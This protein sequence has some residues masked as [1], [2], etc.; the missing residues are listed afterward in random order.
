[1]CANRVKEEYEDE[2]SGT[3]EDNEPPCQQD[4]VFKKLQDV[5][6]RADISEGDRHSEQQEWSSRTEQQEPEPPHIKEEEADITE[7]P[8]T[9]VI[10][11]IEDEYKIECDED[12]CEGSQADNLFAPLSDSDN[13]TS[14][15][16]DT[17]DDEQLKGD[18]TCQTDKQ[19]GKCSQCDKSFPS[20]SL[21]KRHMGIHTRE[22][23]LNYSDCGKRQ[24]AE[25]KPFACS[26]CTLTFRRRCNLITHTRT[27]T[28]E[29]PFACLVCAK[30]FARKGPLNVHMRTHTGEK[31]FACS[32][33]GKRFAR[34]AHLNIH[35]RTHTGEKPFACS[36][37][38]F[39]F[40]EHSGLVLHMR[41]HTGEKPYSCSVCGKRF[42]QS[43][44][45]TTHRRT[46]T[47]EKPFSCSVCDEQFSYKYQMNKHKCS[48]EK[49]SSQ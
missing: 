37:C 3:E 30:R 8:F 11:K 19:R 13:T 16:S 27:H 29:K 18:M 15:S 40:S 2:I 46:H 36:V 34:K 35:T 20:K 39:N 32:L 14:H 44:N 5:L 38:N 45:L 23:Q 33:C 17:E 43:R 26:F 22:K 21:L 24:K 49:S 28:G 6:H 9:C 47:G 10:V 41:T 1:M 12:Q 4:T 42:A 7:L 48:G 31:P 25:G